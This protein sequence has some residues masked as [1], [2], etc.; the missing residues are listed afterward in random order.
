MS[1][2]AA[3]DPV[4]DS[5]I[6]IN[7]WEYNSM[8][9]TLNES[10]CPVRMIGKLDEKNTASLE[11]FNMN[12]PDLA[13]WEILD[14][15]YI[16]PVPLDMGIENYNHLLWD[17]M[18]AYMTVISA[19][20]CLGGTGYRVENVEFEALVLPYPDVPGSPA[21]WVVDA[22]VTVEEYR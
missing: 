18:E 16:F 7:V 11:V 10:E 6:T 21:F 22:V 12:N 2:L 17:Y 8:K 9:D 4:Y 5:D 3:L 14:R 20:P 15:A 13:T 1:S 19:D